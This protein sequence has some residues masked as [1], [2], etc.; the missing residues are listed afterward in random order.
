[1]KNTIT[2]V[3]V[4]LIS[5][6][7]A[8]YGYFVDTNRKQEEA[9]LLAIQKEQERQA[10]I[11]YL[12]PVRNEAQNNMVYPFEEAN[13]DE[14]DS[15]IESI[16]KK[17]NVEGMSV[18]VFYKNTILHT[19]N[20]GYADRQDEI[21]VDDNTKFR[22]ASISKV[23]TAM[24]LMRLYDEG[25]F[26]LDDSI[27]ELTGLQY[28]S[29]YG[30]VTFKDVLTHTAG[31]C[32]SATYLNATDGVRVNI[33]DVLK[34]SHTGSRVGS[35]YLYTN[36]G[37]ASLAS[38]IEVFTGEFFHDFTRDWFVS[39]GLDA[40][41]V[42]TY[43]EDKDSIASIYSGSS[44]Y[45]T[46][47]LFKNKEFYES[48]GLGSTYLQGDGNLII[49]ASDLA[50]LA[51]ILAN[52]GK[53]DGKQVLKAETVGKMLDGYIDVANDIGGIWYTEGLSCHNFHD[54]VKG[55]EIHGHTGSAWGAITAM[56][57]DPN[58][59]TGVVILDNQASAAMDETHN[60][61]VLKEI[62]QETYDAF[63]TYID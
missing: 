35:S 6:V 45:R 3:L 56:Y 48:Y 36:F 53:L 41:Y 43:I 55:R 9:R 37:M 8:F 52:E 12:E 7:T 16:A 42:N 39:L 49:S 2:I 50:R 59:H 32:D 61:K 17:Y 63:F 18:A 22:I 14:Y 19:Y 10:A 29:A 58:E 46:K 40:S 33:N 47:E 57:F 13:L 30:V 27:E 5:I 23:I 54:L 38:V 62:A 25:Y 4:Y 11:A 1:M 26:E 24:N 21:L 34:A 28:D 51:M 44:V 60:R 15:L 20:R 31:L